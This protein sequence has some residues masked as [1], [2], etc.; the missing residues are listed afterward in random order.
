MAADVTGTWLLTVDT[1]SGSGNP[2]MDLQQIG[3]R[4]TGTL[5]SQILGDVPVTGTVKGDRIEFAGEGEAGGVKMK[6]A[7]KGTIQSATAMKGSAAYEGL[8]DNAKWAGSKM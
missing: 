2:T 5:H 8:D 3:E 1:S 4:L 6:I 7:F